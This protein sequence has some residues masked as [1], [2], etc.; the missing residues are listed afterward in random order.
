MSNAKH[1]V[2][3]GVDGSP[4][5]R[6]AAAWAARAAERDRAPLHIVVVDGV[7]SRLTDAQRTVT[8]IAAY[9]RTAAPDATVHEEVDH[10]GFPTEELVRRS[11]DARLIVVGSRGHG[12]FAGAL[13]GSVSSGVAMRATCPVV[14]VRGDATDA[15]PIVVGVDESPASEAALEYAFEAADA[16]GVELIA[17][18]ALPDAHF[19]PGPLPHPDRTEIREQADLHLAEHLA[20]WRERFPDVPVRRTTTNDHPVVALREAA[21]SA[22]LLVVG[23]RGRGGF[24]NLLL[25]S[26]ARGVLHYAPCPVAVVRGVRV[27]E[28]S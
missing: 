4:Q 8:D 11:A 3:V 25:G 22:Q 9:C 5:S 15:G 2:V 23:H 28:R 18:Q 27:R 17:V 1:P 20:G 26:V 14:V 19:V 16:R 10:S 12:G 21:A 13:L 6:Q 24:A 7:P